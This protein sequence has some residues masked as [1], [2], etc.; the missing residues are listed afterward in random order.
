MTFSIRKLLLDDLK[1]ALETIDGSGKFEND[2]TVAG[3]GGGVQ[4]WAGESINLQKTPTAVL[5]WL[6]DGSLDE[7]V[8]HLTRF[9]DVV[10]DVFQKDA[11]LPATSAEAIETL[12]A[13]VERAVLTDP[14]RSEIGT[15]VD[16]AHVQTTPFPSQEDTP[17]IG[18]TVRF[19]IRYSH[20][21]AEPDNDGS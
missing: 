9:L 11:G 19:R 13:D 7:P 5:Y 17:A 10:V 1:T 18:G 4:F 20:V 8:G 3:G 21:R 12:L 14:E 15:N 6:Q 16:T 2:L